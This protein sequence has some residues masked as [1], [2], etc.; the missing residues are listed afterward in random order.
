MFSLVSIDPNVTTL[1]YYD[2]ALQYLTF[3]VEQQINQISSETD[4]FKLQSGIELERHYLTGIDSLRTIS[5]QYN[6]LFSSYFLQVDNKQQETLPN[7]S[8]ELDGLYEFNYQL[9]KKKV[10]EE[11][12]QYDYRSAKFNSFVGVITKLLLA[13]ENI[14]QLDQPSLDLKLISATDYHLQQIQE[15]KFTAELQDV[16]EMIKLNIINDKCVLNPDAMLKLKTMQNDEPEPYYE[17]L[18]GINYYLN[19]QYQEFWSTIVTAMNKCTSS[20][21]LKGMEMLVLFNDPLISGLNKTDRQ[22]FITGLDTYN[23]GNNEEIKHQFSLIKSLYP[24]LAVSY[25]VLAEV[26][27]R[28]GDSFGAYFEYESV[29]QYKPEIITAYEY[30]IKK[31]LDAKN[32]PVAEEKI[33]KVLE[34]HQAWK[35]YFLYAQILYA[36]QKDADALK[37]LET[38]CIVLNKNNYDEY[39]L[40]GDIYKNSGK[41][42]IAR[43]NY[44]EAGRINPQDTYYRNCLN[45]LD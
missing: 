41:N 45:G 1:S 10:L 9:F 28:E 22:R 34:S 40:R 30:F 35:L 24:D 4:F 5:N 44:L 14:F 25:Y 42:E 23:A 13:E 37:I 26:A 3:S 32:Y 29:V 31:E 18:T 38:K 20:Q 16:L 19:S 21:L 8:K 36:Q 7:I 6:T 12:I 33:S 11:L 27:C 2:Q 43:E 17:I 15:F 39:I